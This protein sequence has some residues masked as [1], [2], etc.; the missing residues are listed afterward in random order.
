MSGDFCKRFFSAIALSLLCIGGIFIF[1]KLFILS[2]IFLAGILCTHELLFN[3]LKIKI[4]SFQYLFSQCI[5][6]ILFLGR[7]NFLLNDKV[8]SIVVGL[9]VI[10]H[11]LLVWYFFAVNMKSKILINK[12]AQIS[13]APGLCFLL[14]CLACTIV[15]EH[16]EWAKYLLILI[17]SSQ[18]MD[19]TAW[20]WGKALGKTP[21]CP[22]VSPNKTIAGFIGGTVTTIAVVLIGYQVII[23]DLT[24]SIIAIVVL[25]PP[26]SHLGDLI[27]SK[28]KRQ[29]GLKDSSS[30][31]PGHGGVYDRLDATIFAAPFMTLSVRLFM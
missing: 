31:I 27:Q 4:L 9:A 13:G 29:A 2:L 18:G 7:G 24:Y 12:L 8:E 26:C 16:S 5:F 28:L 3:F 6:I 10:Y 25:L 23:G 21:L 20:V 22:V 14:P 30:L 1:D 15:V 11:L 17:V 19:V